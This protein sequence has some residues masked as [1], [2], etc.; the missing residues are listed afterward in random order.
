MLKTSKITQ[1]DNKESYRRESIIKAP[2][3]RS[4]DCRSWEAN[5]RK[6]S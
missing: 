6:K 4:L 1:D 3:R 2:I 5:A